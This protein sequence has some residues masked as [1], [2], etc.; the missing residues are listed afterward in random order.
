VDSLPSL[1]KCV[2]IW[3]VIVV[4]CIESWMQLAGMNGT[5]A[6]IVHGI[7]KF[8]CILG[9]MDVCKIDVEAQR[10]NGGKDAHF[11][12]TFR[13]ESSPWSSI[14]D[15]ACCF[16]PFDARLSLLLINCIAHVM[17]AG[18]WYWTR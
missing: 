6:R 1:Q 15:F 5:L 12:V 7:V 3:W 2:G 11:Y 18:L 10:C 17:G 4:S 14:G 9:T 16:N 8:G 13:V